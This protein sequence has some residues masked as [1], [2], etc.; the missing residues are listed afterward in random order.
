[1][2]S[3]TWRHLPPP[4]RAIATAAADAVEAAR[5]RDKEAFEAAVEQLGSLDPEQT[6]L[7]LGTVVRNRL[8]ELHPDGLDG[9]DVRAALEGAVRAAIE[10]QEV[11]PQVM[12][13]VLI[14]ALGVHEE[15]DE[16]HRPSPRAL[17]RHAPLLIAFLSAARPFAPDLQRAFAEIERSQVYDS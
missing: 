2:T 4:A 9:D 10:W 6:G 14:G 5:E 3:A 8:E 1:M 7:V 15:A 17:A 11:D 13:V 12:A 16:E